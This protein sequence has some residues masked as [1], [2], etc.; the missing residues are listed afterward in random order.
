VAV[1]VGLVA[2][3]GGSEPA[4]QP[5]TA[6]APGEP[7][8]APDE[9]AWL[10]LLG[11][12]GLEPDRSRVEIDGTREGSELVLTITVPQDAPGEYTFSDGLYG[13]QAWSYLDGGWSRIDTAD[14]R[15]EIAPLLAPGESAEVRLPVRS[16]EGGAPRVLVPVEGFA[17]WTDIS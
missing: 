9:D 11:E 17:A 15:T 10:T 5:P 4:A 13:A 14:I 2:G 16:F 3:C 7:P 8:A 12:L 1:A 6:P